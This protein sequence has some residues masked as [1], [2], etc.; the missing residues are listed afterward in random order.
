MLVDSLTHPTLSG[1]FLNYTEDTS[2]KNI[3]EQLKNNKIDLACAV[4]IPTTGDYSHEA[5]YKEA[6]KHDCFIPVAGLSYTVDLTSEI[7][8]IKN[9]GYRALKIHP[10]F[11]VANLTEKLLI[12]AINLCYKKDITIFLCTYSYSSL[13]NEKG[14]VCLDF[15]NLT[16]ILSSAKPAKIILLHGGGVEILKFSELVRHNSNL[17]LDISFTMCKYETSSIDSDIRFLFEFFDRK[18]CIGSDSPDFAFEHF[19]KRVDYFSRGIEME[20]LKNIK[21]KNIL[22]FLGINSEQR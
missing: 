14:D 17:L 1:S 5:Y 6:L 13:Y 2:F 18:I 20:K 22:S 9:I 8:L 19:L 7:N 21:H 16:K 15:K 12:Q 4:G 10:R 11:L 3:A